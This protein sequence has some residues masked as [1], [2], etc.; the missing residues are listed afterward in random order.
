MNWTRPRR[1]GPWPSPSKAGGQRSCSKARAAKLDRFLCSRLQPGTGS[2]FQ[3][4]GC[5]FLRHKDRRSDLALPP[6]AEEMADRIE[7]QIPRSTPH[8]RSFRRQPAV[9]QHDARGR[10]PYRTTSPASPYP[11]DEA[12]QPPVGPTDPR[13]Q[14]VEKRQGSHAACTA[15][16]I[17]VSFVS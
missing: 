16:G 17:I 6:N 12:L 13:S 5:L 10:S 11:A 8:S 7:N 14:R 4:L 3:L 2:C 15:R 1:F 9:A